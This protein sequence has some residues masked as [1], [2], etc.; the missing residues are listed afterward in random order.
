MS[1]DRIIIIDNSGSQNLQ[2][3]VRSSVHDGIGSER[4]VVE[5]QML[6]PQVPDNLV[7]ARAHSHA[8]F[9]APPSASHVSPVLDGESNILAALSQMLDQRLRLFT[10][11]KQIISADV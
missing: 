3:N 7:D 10:N 6:V 11:P 1:A 8:S 9:S 4:H 5:K 2:G